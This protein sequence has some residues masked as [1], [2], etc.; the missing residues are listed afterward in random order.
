MSLIE[1]LPPAEQ[2]TE[3]N[4]LLKSK[5]WKIV[6]E[7]L[8]GDIEAYVSDLKRKDYETLEKRNTDKEIL[9]NLEGLQEYPKT[10]IEELKA[11]AEAQAETAAGK[12]E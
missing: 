11:E 5:G 4:K 8:Q 9:E 10:H 3:L 2:V 1:K 12:I 7:L 6:C